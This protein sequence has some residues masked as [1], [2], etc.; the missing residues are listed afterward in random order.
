MNDKC[1]DGELKPRKGLIYLNFRE[2]IAYWYLCTL[3]VRR[4]LVATFKQTILGPLWFVIQPV[5]TTITFTIVFGNLAGLSTDG[6]PKILFYLS[7]VT[8]WGY[9]SESLTKTSNT[10][11]ANQQMF[12]KVYFPRIIVPISVIITNLIRFGIQLLLFLLVL[13]YY[14]IVQPQLVHP[15]CT[16]VFLPIM[17]L[18]MAMLGLGLGTIIS[19]L[20]TKYK[21]LKH[22]VVFGVQLLMYASPIIYPLS[23]LNGKLRMIIWSNPMT[24]VIHNFKVAFLGVGEFDYIGMIYSFVFGMVILF[25][26]LMVFTRVE[27]TFIDTV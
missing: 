4:D 14:L 6:L 15:S 8:V 16:I 22:L 5:L 24:S 10:F 1:W 25:F 20:T 13:G 9:F 18:T 27:R 21:D 12:G 2:I 26:G 7:G 19:A 23:E 3:F 11:D 17:I